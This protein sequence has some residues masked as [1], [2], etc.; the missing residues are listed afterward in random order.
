MKK[1]IILLSFLFT[2]TLAY[3][4]TEPYV[5]KLKMRKAI[6]DGTSLM[7]AKVDSAY[8]IGKETGILVLPS[9][10][11]VFGVKFT[12]SEKKGERSLSVVVYKKEMDTWKK[13]DQGKNLGTNG[14]FGTERSK[15]GVLLYGMYF[16]FRLLGANEVD[17]YEK[18]FENK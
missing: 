11:D 15:N 10:G 17:Y 2:A 9:Q 12:V 18:L 1:I 4:Q 5:V 16:D 8:K 6:M 7:P 14:G 3:T 13:I